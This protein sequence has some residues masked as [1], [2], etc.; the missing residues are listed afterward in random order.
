VWTRQKSLKADELDEKFHEGEDI[1]EFLDMSWA[2]R[3]GP[4]LIA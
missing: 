4:E 3:P 1:S 2:T